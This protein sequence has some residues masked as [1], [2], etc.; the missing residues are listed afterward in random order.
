MSIGINL[1]RSTARGLNP[2]RTAGKR[3]FV[4]TNGLPFSYH[5]L[6]KTL[7]L[8]FPS[9]FRALAPETVIFCYLNIA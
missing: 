6:T 7:G 2:W 3:V 4:D 1:S 5:R 9:S 8:G